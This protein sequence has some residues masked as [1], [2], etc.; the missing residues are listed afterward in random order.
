MVFKDDVIVYL[1]VQRASMGK[2]TSTR[3]YNQ[4]TNSGKKKYI[5]TSYDKLENIMKIKHDKNKS[6]VKAVTPILYRLL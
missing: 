5:Y 1:E 2:T 3:Q 4:D 6:T